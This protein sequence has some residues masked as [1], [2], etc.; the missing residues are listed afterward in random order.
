MTTSAR[1]LRRLAH[2]VDTLS[3]KDAPERLASYLLNL[4]DRSPNSDWVELNLSKGQ[5]AALLGTTPETLSP[6]FYKLSQEGLIEISGKK[7]YL[8]DRTQ[9]ATL[10]QKSGV[11]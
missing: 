6:T 11:F 5:L 10:G 1:H 9:L 4:S 7:I 3:F 8:C 2:R